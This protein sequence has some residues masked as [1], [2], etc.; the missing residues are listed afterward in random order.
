MIYWPRYVDNWRGGTAT[1]SLV[2]KGVYGELLDYC[3]AK[4]CGL[5]L[6][7]ELIWRIAGARTPMEH[8]AVDVVLSR[9]FTKTTTG[10]INERCQ[11]EIEKWQKKKVAKEK[12]GY[13]R[14]GK[15]PPNG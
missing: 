4:E 12:G 5:P 1:L 7:L 6:Q 9:F 11:K 13:A 2:E 8:R 14:W 10:W 3:Y 15:E